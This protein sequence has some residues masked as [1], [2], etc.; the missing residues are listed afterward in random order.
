MS[1]ARFGFLESVRINSL[2]V[3]LRLLTCPSAIL[4]RSMRSPMPY[5]GVDNATRT[6]TISLSGIAYF[7]TKDNGMGGSNIEAFRDKLSK[8][9]YL[10]LE[11]EDVRIA[12]PVRGAEPITHFEGKLRDGKWHSIQDFSDGTKELLWWLYELNWGDT[13][14]HRIICIDEI[15]RSLHPQVQE[16]LI[17]IIVG[18]S[19]HQQFFITTHSVY[20]ADPYKAAKIHKLNGKGS[21]MSVPQSDFPKHSVF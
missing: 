11:I 20:M 21:I 18:R 12:E 4:S 15:E 9:S 6:D 19:S 16:A 7:L 8:L 17:Q 10:G 2:L 3:F 14:N 1:L 5:E 13:A